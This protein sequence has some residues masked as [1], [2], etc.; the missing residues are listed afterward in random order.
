MVHFIR[1]FSPLTG[2]SCF[3]CHM[4]CCTTEYDLPIFQEEKKKI[5]RKL[6]LWM[7]F[8][9][10]SKDGNY[11]LRGD[12]CPFLNEKGL[13][14]LHDTNDKPLICQIYPLIFYRIK[15]DLFLTWISPCRGNGFQ[16]VSKPENQVKNSYI[17]VIL[18][19][20]NPY[21][22]VYIG[23]KIDKANPYDS[24]PIRRIKEQQ[25][26]FTALSHSDKETALFDLTYS[27]HYNLFHS[28]DRKLEDFQLQEDLNNI[29]NAV[30]YWLFWSPVGLQL[31]FNNSKLVFQV[32]GNWIKLWGSNLLLEPELP[33]IKERVLEQLGS[34][35]ATSILPSF[36]KQ[37]AEKTTDKPLKKFSKLVFL[38]LTGTRNQEILHGVLK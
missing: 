33:I 14:I 12:S 31:S 37:M 17:D 4:K 8:L 19:K 20:A 24:I 25:K 10:S 32:A 28:L 15:P 11:I 23:E 18:E 22:K 27:N 30:F 26:F 5:A 36:W 2:Y 34:F 1:G 29:L 38:V 35:Y 3:H 9:K 16:W 13:C 6:P 7:N 21:F